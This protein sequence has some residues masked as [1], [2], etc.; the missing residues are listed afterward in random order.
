MAKEG[1]T[2]EHVQQRCQ[3]QRPTANSQKRQAANL[4]GAVVYAGECPVGKHLSEAS[5][6]ERCSRR[7][8]LLSG[9]LP[10][11]RRRTSGRARLVLL[12]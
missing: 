12:W 6:K 10:P 3:D 2:S 1:K 5:C 7:L 8:I 11:A 4:P 9:P